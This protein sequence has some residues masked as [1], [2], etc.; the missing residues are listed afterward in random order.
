MKICFCP[1]RLDTAFR[2]HRVGDVLTINGQDFDFSELPEGAT[3]PRAAIACDWL[4]SDVERRD[5]VICLALM[6][7][8]GPGAPEALR[9]PV[10]LILSEDGPVDL[11][12]KGGSDD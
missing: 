2:L 3:L 5:G 10:P 11:T 12:F 6:L 8:I 4:A 1:I 9:F 7:P